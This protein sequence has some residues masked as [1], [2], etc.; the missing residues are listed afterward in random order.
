MASSDKSK[1]AA[2]EDHFNQN[3]FL[4]AFYKIKKNVL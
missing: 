2:G 1:M 3:V 4:L